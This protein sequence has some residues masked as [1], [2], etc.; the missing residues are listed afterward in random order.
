MSTNNGSAN[1]DFDNR[2]LSGSE[3]YGDSLSQHEIDQWFEDEK[4]GYAELGYAD[5]L[6]AAEYKYHPFNEFLLYRHLPS[7]ALGRA[8]GIGSAHGAEFLPISAR[9]SSVTIVEPSETLRADSVGGLGIEYAMPRSDGVLSFEDDSFEL[10]TSLGVLHHIPNVSKVLG[11]IGRVVSPGGFLALREPVQSMGDWR[12]PRPGLTR[13]E[14]GIPPGILDQF[15]DAAGFSIV[16]RTWCDFPT[17]GRLTKPSSRIGVRLDAM[18][19]RAFS[20]NFSYHSRTLRSRL[21]PRSLAIVA[22]KRS[23]DRW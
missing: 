17:M 10:V 21:R 20:S 15:L 7:G 5:G 4:E 3:L 23:V 14:R 16:S 2:F 8:L 9:L 19:S 12:L 18:L 11:E 22:R 13:R 6:Y 1:A